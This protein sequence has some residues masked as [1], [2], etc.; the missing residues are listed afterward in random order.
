MLVLVL[1]LAGCGGG[2]PEPPAP[3]ASPA[4]DPL[5]STA[6]FGERL[7][8]PGGVHTVAAL[9]GSLDPA[10]V[11]VPVEVAPDERLVAAVVAECASAEGAVTLSQRG[12]SVVLGDGRTVASSAEPAAA[13]EGSPSIDAS[14]RVPAGRCRYARMLFVV[15]RGEAVAAVRY[16][17]DGVPLTTWRDSGSTS[18]DR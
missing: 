17:G 1:V 2:Q 14:H 9:T 13:P 16:D 11:G 15:P 12:W 5:G 10:D 18:P 8:A 6:G 7:D 3:S 4:S